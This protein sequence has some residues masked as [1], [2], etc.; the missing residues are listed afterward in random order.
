MEVWLGS[1]GERE[2]KE[3]IK[4]CSEGAAVNFYI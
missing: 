4:I 2:G 1:E 3:R